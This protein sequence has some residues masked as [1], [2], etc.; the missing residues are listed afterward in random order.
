MRFSE[1]QSEPAAATQISIACSSSDTAGQFVGAMAA[2]PPAL[3][4]PLHQLPTF[5]TDRQHR[6]TGNLASQR[7][8]SFRSSQKFPAISRNRPFPM[9]I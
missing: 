5:K 8:L 7:K 4:Q 6:G 3:V 1:E 9:L 2:P